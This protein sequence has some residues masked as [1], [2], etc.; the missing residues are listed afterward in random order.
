MTQ[1]NEL[2]K[3]GYKILKQ[4][5]VS[6]Y[7]L[8]TELILSNVLNKPRGKILTEFNKD[9]SEELVQ[10]FYK[11]LLRRA[12]KEPIAYIFRE[13]EFWSKKFFVNNDTLIP[14]PETELMIEKT[15]K[16]FYG[17]KWERRLQK[18]RDYSEAV[19]DNKL[20]ITYYSHVS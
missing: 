12:R 10:N 7:Q 16:Y 11:L 13:K 6:T 9:I 5:L 14:R 8:D 1:I 2:I 3:K 19:E 15:S 4:N 17:K 20:K 18:W